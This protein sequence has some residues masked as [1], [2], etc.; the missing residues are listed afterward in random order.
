MKYEP[1]APTERSLYSLLMQP[2]NYYDPSDFEP[3]WEL[4]NIVADTIDS[5][6]PQDKKVI[7][8][9]YYLRF[10]FE[11]LATYIGTRAKSHAWRKHKQAV[12]NFRKALEANPEYIQYKA[13]KEHDK[14][15]DM[16]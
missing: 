16:G 1:E 13:R 7:I 10:T 15:Q 6:S 5:L 9:T 14:L 2:F 8:G 4:L 12:E 3:D 11:Q